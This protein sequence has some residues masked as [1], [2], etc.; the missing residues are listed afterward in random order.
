MRLSKGMQIQQNWLFLM[1][2]IMAPAQVLL[3]EKDPEMREQLRLRYPQFTCH[4]DCLNLIQTMHDEQVEHLDCI[5]SG[6]PFYNF[7]QSVREQLLEQIVGALRENG[8]FIAFQYSK[9]ML[10]QFKVH[11]VIEHIHYV[12]WNFPPAFVYVCRKKRKRGSM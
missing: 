12:P 3:F 4:E 1:K 5:F 7:P 11:F 8:W 6:L 2:F 9:Q 10:E